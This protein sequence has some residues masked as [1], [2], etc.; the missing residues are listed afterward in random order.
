[1][2]VYVHGSGQQD[3]PDVLHER[4]DRSLF[5]EPNP[6][7]RLAY[8]ADVLHGAEH[9][10]VL[11]RLRDAAPKRPREA[12]R[13]AAVDVA[14]AAARPTPDELD[15]LEDLAPDEPARSRIR[16]LR[17]RIQRH[18]D[19]AVSDR[20]NWLEREAFRVLL[21]TLLPDVGAYFF[22]GRGE[23]M[24]E[25]LR[26]ILRDSHEPITLVSHSLG[27][28]IAYHV[29]QEP[30]LAELDVVDWITLGSPLGIDEVRWLAT[31]G[32]AHPAPVPATVRRWTNIADPLDPVAL[33]GTP[34]DEFGPADRIADLQ[35]SILCR[36]H[37]AMKAYLATDHVRAVVLGPAR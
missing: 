2:L 18:E 10:G 19:R 30:A 14:V 27:T 25:P 17:A 35:V 11:S 8:Y 33:D 16:A 29:L 20:P 31:R 13:Q 6:A 23:E 22:G 34:A 36:S 5:G 15:A 24:R 37:H 21:A 9:P 28:V 32:L 4:L 1:M 3:P 26:R 7:T 12:L